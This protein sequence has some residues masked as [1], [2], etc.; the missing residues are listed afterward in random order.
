MPTL[1]HFWSELMI[2]AYKQAQCAIFGGLILFFLI[3]TKY[4]SVPFL[5]RYDFLFII[6]ILIQ[7]ALVFFKLEEKKEVFVIAVFHI[8]A[9]I[10][11]VFKTSPAVGSWSYPEPAIAS[12]YSVPL[13]TGF[14]YSAI[15]S[16]IARS[17]RI[18]KFR[19]QNMPRRSILML[20]GLA[21]YVN[22][23][24]NHFTYDVRYELFALLI[25]I[26]WKTKIHVELTRKTY[27]FHPLITNALLA[28]FVWLSEQIGTFARAWVYPNQ[29]EVWRPVS[30]HMYTSWYMLL[31]FSFVII[32]V[33]YQKRLD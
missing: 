33:L 14:M 11:E 32:S 8:F 20:I 27:V 30:F 17:W 25:I 7:I 13:F 4:V 10:M 18:N 15:G 29:A 31:I 9:M 24:T 19:F 22:F 26:F 5:H 1:K 3:L 23:F 28:L 2:F 21:I 12:I 6:A 16:Y